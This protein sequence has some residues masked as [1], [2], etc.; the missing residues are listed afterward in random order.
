[1][2][3]DGW[4]HPW[5]IPM[6]MGVALW[7]SFGGWRGGGGGS[8]LVGLGVGQVRQFTGFLRHRVWTLST[9]MQSPPMV[10]HCTQCTVPHCTGVSLPDDQ[11]I[12][13]VTERRGLNYHH[14]LLI[15]STQYGTGSTCHQ[16]HH[17]HHHHDQRNLD[18]HR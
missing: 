13:S 8:P 5:V 6:M 17:N 4:A 1:M 10:V 16:Y 18:H 9:P 14:I 11:V 2:M 3:V 7:W 15:P 12:C